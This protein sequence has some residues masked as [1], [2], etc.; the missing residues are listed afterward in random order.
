MSPARLDAELLDQG[1]SGVAIDLERL[2][3]AARPVE[4][5]HELPAKPFAQRVKGRQPL[6]LADRLTE[7][8][9]AQVG[10][11]PVLERRQP[12]LLQPG[13]LRLKRW[14][15]AEVV[16]R[17][18]PPQVERPVQ[19]LGCGRG[20]LSRS[21]L[22]H[23]LLEAVEV[24]PARLNA[25]L[26]AGLA[27]DQGVRPDRLTQPGYGHL[28]RLRSL[29]DPRFPPELV[30]EPVARDDLV[31]VKEQQRQKR[32]L[33]RAANRHRAIAVAYVEGAEDAEVHLGG[34]SART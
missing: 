27:G 32:P 25:Q 28:E 14:F 8:A 15:E 31:R 18:P 24:E 10:L 7:A 12:E 2:G 9:E 19:G 22:R 30:H 1:A 16:E 6:E 29:P 21:A 34:S 13:E 11:D 20:V 33:P 3:L 5:E 26:I 17:R 23:E 4:R